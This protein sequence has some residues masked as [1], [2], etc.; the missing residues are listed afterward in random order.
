MSLW[1]HRNGEMKLLSRF[2]QKKVYIEVDWLGIDDWC[3]DRV[4]H[5]TD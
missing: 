3:V 4:S 2:E 1:V 5:Q